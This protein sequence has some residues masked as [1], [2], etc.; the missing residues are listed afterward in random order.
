MR[1]NAYARRCLIKH[2]AVPKCGSYEVRYLDGR[3]SQGFYWDDLVG[4]RLSPDAVDG[5]TA[6]E[7]AKDFVRAERDS[8]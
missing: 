6:L 3:P 2:E 4:R 8:E 7:R 5:Q 1:S